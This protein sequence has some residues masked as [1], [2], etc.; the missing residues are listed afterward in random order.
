MHRRHPEW[1]NR[2]K[3]PA[4]PGNGMNTGRIGSAAINQDNPMKP[5]TSNDAA[6]LAVCSTVLDRT[7]EALP[8]AI[9]GPRAASRDG[10][11]GRAWRG[12]ATAKSNDA[13]GPFRLAFLETLLRAAAAARA[14]K[15]E[16]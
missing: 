9:A 6:F 7:T 4:M 5:L 15:L 1:N 14:S 10:R 11:K 12:S 8:P 2:R 3:T 13:V 16:K